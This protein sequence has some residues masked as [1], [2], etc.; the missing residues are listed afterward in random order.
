VDFLNDNGNYDIINN[1]D[2]NYTPQKNKPNRR[3]ASMTEVVQPYVNSLVKDKTNPKN[4]KLLNLV[5]E[6]DNFYKKSDNFRINSI[7][8]HEDDELCVQNKKNMKAVIDNKMTM[9]NQSKKEKVLEQ[10]SS[11][12]SP[13]FYDNNLPGIYKLIF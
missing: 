7:N 3:S 13:E 2:V 4:K 10:T 6:F 11:L 5:S 1:K 12:F 9:S 8:K